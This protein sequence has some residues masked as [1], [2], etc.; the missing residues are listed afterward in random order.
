MN[1]VLV[2]HGS[3]P[4][5]AVF[6]EDTETPAAVLHAAHVGVLTFH[7]IQMPLVYFCPTVP[8]CF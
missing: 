3:H 5:D 4:L 6:Q 7:P 1:T 8:N 2:I